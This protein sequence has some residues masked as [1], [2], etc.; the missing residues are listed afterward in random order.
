MLK[1][2][3]YNTIYSQWIYIFVSQN[4]RV[5]QE[6]INYKIR[7][8][9]KENFIGNWSVNHDIYLRRI[10]SV[11][12]PPLGVLQ[13]STFLMNFL[14]DFDV[15]EALSNN[16]MNNVILKFWIRLWI[17]FIDLTFHIPSKKIFHICLITYDQE[18]IR[19]KYFCLYKSIVSFT[20][21][22]W[23]N[24]SC[25]LIFINSLICLL[26]IGVNHQFNERHTSLIL[27]VKISKLIQRHLYFI[28]S[29]KNVQFEIF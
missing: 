5:F 11:K 23:N 9:I 6:W 8:H 7:I 3:F 4:R 10:I 25:K 17:I 19:P 21:W 24:I 22:S 27:N 2:I 16:Q 14:W 29:Q 26:S 15:I 18:I 12:W 20:K 28:S 13:T 1:W